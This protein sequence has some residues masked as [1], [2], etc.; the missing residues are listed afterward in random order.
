MSFYCACHADLD[1]AFST[2]CVLSKIKLY[3]LCQLTSVD[4]FIFHLTKIH[5]LIDGEVVLS[6]EISNALSYYMSDKTTEYA[7]L[8]EKHEEQYVTYIF[9]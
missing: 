4:I 7:V 1:D 8:F 2:N 9:S 3:G 5:K 6:P